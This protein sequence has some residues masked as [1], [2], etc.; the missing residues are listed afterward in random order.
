MVPRH[1]Q[2]RASTA[3]GDTVSDMSHPSSSRKR[4]FVIL[5]LL[6]AAVVIYRKATADTGG[7]FDP[8]RPE[9]H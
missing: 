8:D 2:H 4:T 3:R 9:T 1:P 6:A 5:A 7:T